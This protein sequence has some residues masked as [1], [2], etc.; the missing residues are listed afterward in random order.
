MNYK[1]KPSNLLIYYGWLNS[2]NSVK[3]QWNNENVAQEFAK[4]DLLVFGDG[5]QYPSHGDFIN[6][7]IILERIKEL[8]PNSLIFG[9]VT[10]N[11]DI[12]LFKEKVNQWDE[13][14][15][16][17][18]FFDE[19][20]YDYNTTRQKQNDRLMFVKNRNCNLCFVNAWN[21]NHVIGLE[22]DINFPNSVY[23]ADLIE[24]ILDDQDWYLLESFVVNTEAYANDGICFKDDFISKGNA[25][26]Y[27]RSKYDIKLA[28]VNIINDSNVK[29]QKLFNF[30]YNGALMFSLDAVGSSSELYGANS[31]KVE[32]MVR[33]TN[34]IGS[35]QH[36]PQ[37][38]IDKLNQNVCIRHG[39]FSKVL[40][41]FTPANQTSSIVKW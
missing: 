10:A 5:L 33:P 19:M 15:V 39:Q 28:A 27:N 31:A 34:N 9:Y 4:Y 41:D 17:G 26:C 11:Q 37:V 1:A 36:I 2:F 13:L 24:S 23:N 21:I 12:S 22:S 18:I 29:K 20:G 8:N 14:D 6:T 25:A 38:T 3:N 30:C 35:T 16:D 40:L 32:F 7:T